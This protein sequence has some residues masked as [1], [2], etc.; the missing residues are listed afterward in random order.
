MPHPN[1]SYFARRRRKARSGLEGGRMQVIGG[2]NRPDALLAPGVDFIFEH[3]IQQDA[4]ERVIDTLIDFTPPVATRLNGRKY[5]GENTARELGRLVGMV[6]GDAAREI[7]AAFDA[8]R[9]RVE[10]LFAT[11]QGVGEQITD[12]LS[13]PLSDPNTISVTPPP[14]AEALANRQ[15]ELDAVTTQNI[16]DAEAAKPAPEEASSN[17]S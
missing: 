7:Q 9:E 8:Y 17:G 10:A 13:S 16:K 12:V 5:I 11:L 3:A 1:D 2:K 15:A 6:D 14:D 4:G